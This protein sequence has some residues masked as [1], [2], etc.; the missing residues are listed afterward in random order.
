MNLAIWEHLKIGGKPILLVAKLGLFENG[1]VVNLLRNKNEKVIN[2]ENKSVWLK[3][4][5]KLEN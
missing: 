4:M 1:Y 5:L 2:A 3:I